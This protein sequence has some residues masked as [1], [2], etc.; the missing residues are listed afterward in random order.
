MDPADA[1][2]TYFLE[3]PRIAINQAPRLIV[4]YGRENDPSADLELHLGP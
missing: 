2:V 4:L 1:M 3:H